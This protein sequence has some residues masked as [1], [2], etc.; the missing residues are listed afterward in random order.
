ME[1]RHQSRAS[2]SRWPRTAAS[3]SSTRNMEPADQSRRGRQGEAVGERLIVDPVTCRPDQKDL[4]GAPG[5]GELPDLGR[6]R[7]RLAR[8]ARRH[9][10]ER[11][12]RFE[13]RMDLP[14]SERMT[15]ENLVTCPP[16]TTLEQAKEL[17]HPPDR[18]APRRRPRR[19]PEGADHGQGH[20]EADQVPGRQQGLAR[21]L[22][23][24]A[25]SASVRTA[26]PAPAVVSAKVDLI[27]LDSLRTA[28]ASRP[29]R[30]REVEADVPSTPVMAGTSP[31]P[32]GT[33][34]L[35]RRGA[36]AV[37]IGI[38]PRLHLHDARRH[39]PGVP[40]IHAIMGVRAGPGRVEG[41]PRRRRRQSSS[42]ADV[43][44]AL[45]AGADAVMIGSLLRRHRRGAGRDD[46]LPGARR[47]RRTA[48]WARSAP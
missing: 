23:V 22:R 21:R 27:V 48:A 11:D 7:R 4:R 29:R 26:S 16:G 12:L 3:T 42:R 34:D 40:Q 33:R 41:P 1:H 8:E 37:K 46:P 45:A 28:T 47:S 25:L 35:I 10:D 38:G 24:A 6:P 18:E 44:K 17:L 32:R 31:R 43:T 2:R 20:P 36:D 19:E 14:I 5:H 15:K 39:R 13:T 30:A 9:P